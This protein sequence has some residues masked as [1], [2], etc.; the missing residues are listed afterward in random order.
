MCALF[1]GISEGIAYHRLW[2][3][4]CYSLRLGVRHPAKRRHLQMRAAVSQG[5]RPHADMRDDV[6]IEY[7]HTVMCQ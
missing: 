1:G 4:W 6:P 3:V 2:V 7:T 5:A